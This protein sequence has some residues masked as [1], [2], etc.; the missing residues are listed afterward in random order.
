VF[1]KSDAGG[2]RFLRASI[3]KSGRKYDFRAQSRKNPRR[4]A[5]RGARESTKAEEPQHAK[6]AALGRRRR[7]GIRAFSAAS[8]RS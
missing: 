1:V 5:R 4:A 2:A 6:F 8:A 7:V 3:E